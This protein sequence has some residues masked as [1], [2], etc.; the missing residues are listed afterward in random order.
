MVLQ[1]GCNVLDLGLGWGHVEDGQMGTEGR[2]KHPHT[3]ASPAPRSQG[4][5]NPKV[6]RQVSKI[7]THWGEGGLT[8]RSSQLWPRTPLTWDKSYTS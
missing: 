8:L 7:I 3:A 2:Y 1:A 6:A 5:Q 4:P